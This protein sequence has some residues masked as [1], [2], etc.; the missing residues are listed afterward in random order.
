VFGH[1]TIA[2]TYYYWH[3]DTFCL[4]DEGSSLPKRSY[5]YLL[6]DWIPVAVTGRYDTRNGTRRA[7][8][9]NRV[10]S[11]GHGTTWSRT[12]WSERV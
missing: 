8:R 12:G 1:I 7:T 6:Q 2:R 11:K 3:G 10:R 4:L 5:S 9:S